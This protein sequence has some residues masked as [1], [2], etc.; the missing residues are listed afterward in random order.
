VPGGGRGEFYGPIKD[1]TAFAATGKFVQ[2]A[3][4]SCDAD[5]PQFPEIINGAF[6]PSAGEHPE[7]CQRPCGSARAF[8][9]TGRNIMK[10]RRLRGQPRSFP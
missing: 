6:M 4:V 10:R 1:I 3:T 9:R 7:F 8:T 2:G 5:V